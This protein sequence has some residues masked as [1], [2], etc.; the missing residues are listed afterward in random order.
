MYA[1]LTLKW[2]AIV[3]EGPVWDYRIQQLYWVDILRGQLHK[4]APSTS[5]NIT[6]EIGLYVGA[7]V[8]C[9]NGGLVLAM[10]NGWGFYDEETKQ[11]SAISDPEENKP[12][13]RFNDGK[14]DSK[15]R[16]WSGTMQIDPKDPVGSLYML[17][18]DL[19]SSLK[20]N[21]VYISNGL[22]WS[23]NDQWFYYIDS[24]RYKIACYRFESESGSITFERD[25]ISIDQ[26]MGIPDGMTIDADGNLW[27]AIY[28][29]GCILSINPNSGKIVGRVEVPAKKT[30]S[31]TFGGE[32]LDTLFITTI[33]EDTDPNTDPLAGSIF[34]VKPGVKGTKANFF[35]GQMPDAH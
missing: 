29:G 26:E 3:G 31:C 22:A 2:D 25:I 13:N 8:P 10:K 9:S 34:S 30:S 21:E 7:A 12:A 4:F 32:D 1:E 17:D 23:Q 18:T 14:V 11:L 20:L 15:G 27:V 19:K 24:L 16:L 28:D 33:S 5:Q 6:Y 35:G